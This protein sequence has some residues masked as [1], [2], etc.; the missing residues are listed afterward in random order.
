MDMHFPWQM[1]FTEYIFTSHSK[2]QTF[3]VMYYPSLVG[4]GSKGP[5][6]VYLESL[7]RCSLIY[8]QLEHAA[9][10]I[11]FLYNIMVKFGVQN[12]VAIYMKMRCNNSCSISRYNSRS[13]SHSNL[14]QSMFP[15]RIIIIQQWQVVMQPVAERPCEKKNHAKL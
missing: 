13:I 14:L 11:G 10:D 4:S 9:G 12:S 8:L 7:V 3:P 2:Y 6:E 15:G 5:T 1:S